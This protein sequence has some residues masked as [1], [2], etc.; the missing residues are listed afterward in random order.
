MYKNIYIFI[1]GCLYTYL[2][3]REL[4][5]SL[6]NR[7]LNIPEAE[8]EAWLNRIIELIVAQNLEDPHVSIENVKIAIQECVEPNKLKNTETV[9]NII[10]AYEIPKMKYDICRKKFVIDN[11]SSYPE[12]QYKSLIFKN[13]FEIVW[14]KTLRHKQFLSCKFEKPQTDKMNLIPIEY[15]LSELK[16][17][18]VCTM[19]MITQLTEDQYY[20]EDT[21]GIIK[22]NLTGA[23]SFMTYN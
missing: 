20:L 16:T 13:R 19:G 2:I 14:Y 9:F 21:S 6:A 4:R 1:Y 7:L 11:E 17:G 23:I 15:L 18:N 22:I 5:I 8:R 3:F 12:A 10:N